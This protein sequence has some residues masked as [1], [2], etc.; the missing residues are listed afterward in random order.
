MRGQH[1]GFTAVQSLM[2]Q[3]PKLTLEHLKS[4]G[5]DPTSM[6]YYKTVMCNYWRSMVP[7]PP[8]YSPGP[9]RAFPG[10]M[11]LTILHPVPDDGVAHPSR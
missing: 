8:I 9:H 7:S 2:V 5:Q 3:S 4:I 1:S 11:M 6:P 10:C